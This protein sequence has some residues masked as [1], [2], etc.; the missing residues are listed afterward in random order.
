MEPKDLNILRIISL[1]RDIITS[2]I[3]GDL[4]NLSYSSPITKLDKIVE[5]YKDRLQKRL[6]STFSKSWV[7]NPIVSVN[8]SIKDELVNEFSKETISEQNLRIYVANKNKRKRLDDYDSGNESRDLSHIALEDKLNAFLEVKQ[9]GI[10]LLMRLR[11]CN[12]EDLVKYITENIRNPK[13]VVSNINFV[14]GREDSGLSDRQKE[15]LREYLEV[16][17]LTSDYDPE[18]EMKAKRELG[19]DPFIEAYCN[20]LIRVAKLLE[21]QGKYRLADRATEILDKIVLS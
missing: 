5:N 10:N 14:L 16:F 4:N 1:T 19:K 18:A 3:A 21:D 12:Y 20:R 8:A 17:N 9:Y 6:Q 15:Y 11:I 13:D 2:D 7:L